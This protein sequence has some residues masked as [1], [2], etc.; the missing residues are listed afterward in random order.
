MPG[1]S[2]H[3]EVAVAAS[4]AR[5]R[6]WR[7]AAAGV[8]AL[9][10]AVAPAA[11]AAAQP[12]FTVIASGLDGPRGL[13]FG[14]DGALYVAEAGRGGPTVTTE[15]PCQQVPPPVGPY[16]GG[17]TA[18]VSRIVN[19]E[20]TTVVEGLPSGL[21]SLPSGDTVGA[22]DVAFLGS[23]LYVLVAGGGCSHGNPEAPAGIVRAKI[24]QGTW[25]YTA[26]LSAY[27]HSHPVAHPELGDF[28]PD[29]TLFTMVVL[30]GHF[31]A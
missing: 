27:L 2:R 4:V 29:G 16:H 8:I 15:P 3:A 26:N 21:S 30:N 6:A 20:R 7:F 9:A 10:M 25:N 13:E 17:P 12:S 11:Q 5:R 28:E 18:R 14:P 1:D 24:T 22:A 31:Y 19:G 23:N